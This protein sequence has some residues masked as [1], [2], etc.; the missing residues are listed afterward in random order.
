MAGIGSCWI[1]LEF[2][3][4]HEKMRLAL[5]LLQQAWQAVLALRTARTSPDNRKTVLR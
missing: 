1:D 5:L 4:Q 2:N 3:Q